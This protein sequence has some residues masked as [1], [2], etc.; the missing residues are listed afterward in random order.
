MPLPLRLALTLAASLALVACST[1]RPWI[2]QPR[3]DVPE[4][5]VRAVAQR[6]ASSLFAVSLSGGGARAAAFAFGVLK[7]LRDTPCC[8]YQR[9]SNVLDAVDLISGV[10]GGSIVA[11]YFAAFGSAG[12]DQFEP[13]FLRQDFQSGLIAQLMHPANL[14][15]LSSPWFGRSQLLERRLDALYRGMTFRDIE[16]RPRHPQLLIT[17]TDLTLGTGFDFTSDTFELIC[18]DL[19]SVPLSF[20]VTASSAV[21]LLLS[22]MTLRN[23]RDDCP[24]GVPKLVERPAES[25]EDDYRTRLI[26]AQQR[27]YLDA[28]SRPYIHLVDGG[29]ADNLGVRRWIET[30][31]AGGG[32]R[33]AFREVRI[34]AGSVQRLVLV[35]VNAERDPVHDIS[36]SDQVPS[37]TDVVD[38]LLFGAGNQ[39]SVETQEFLTDVVRRFHDDIARGERWPGFAKD[40]EIYLI[41][42]NL[43][44]ATGATRRDLMQVPTAF[45]IGDAEV[46]SLIEAGRTVLRAS[47]EFQALK[48]SLGFGAT[49]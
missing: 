14:Y 4:I 15:D 28:Q 24:G 12:L 3:V 19:Q 33:T 49:P 44:D 18:S 40:A 34:P 23:Y 2:N 6:D 32:M 38:A 35:I 10:S 45:T 41:F 8:W 46:T 31:L 20:A 7:E 37:T 17:A 39:A 36:A 47:K 30:A 42:V 22:P 16:H 26:L 11:A 43:R 13:D 29:L 21:P 1:V 27:A 5:D 9:D 25:A 48:R